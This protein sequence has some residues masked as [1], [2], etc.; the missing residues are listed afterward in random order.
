MLTTDLALR[1]DPEYLGRD[2]YDVARLVV[3]QVIYTKAAAG[4]DLD[5]VRE[6]VE[7]EFGAGSLERARRRKSGRAGQVPRNRDHGLT[8]GRD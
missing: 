7:S 2:A 6:R 8:H 5:S 4:V 3:V 1:V